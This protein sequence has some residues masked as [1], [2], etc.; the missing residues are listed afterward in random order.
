MSAADIAL[1]KPR[2]VALSPDGEIYVADTG[3]SRV[4]SIRA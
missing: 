4:R 1:N 3:N 2:A